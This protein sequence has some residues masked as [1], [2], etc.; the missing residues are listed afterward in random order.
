MPQVTMS[1]ELA[2][3]PNELWKAIGGF[4]RIA[5]WHPAIERADIEGEEG[6]KGTIRRLRLVGGG[7]IVER[8]EEISP[9][10][11]VYRYTIEQGP[12]PVGS[13]EAE[14]RVKDNGDGTSTVEWS[15]SFE[16]KGVSDREA[17]EIIQGIYK[18]GLD[19]L[20]KLYGLKR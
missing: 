2:A 18:A 20:A 19:N 15:S 4:A 14:I 17:V 7:E 16:A 1:T 5:D 6:K 11:R 3:D 10:E 8:L 9:T 13:Y 12:L